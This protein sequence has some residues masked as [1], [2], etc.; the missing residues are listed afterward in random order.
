MR[1]FN[2]ILTS[3][4]ATGILV[5]SSLS[6]SVASTNRPETPNWFSIDVNIASKVK[7][8]LVVS[9]YGLDANSTPNVV[10]PNLAGDYRG[11]MKVNGFTWQV[12]PSNY[13]RAFDM[14]SF[15]LTK[16]QSQSIRSIYVLE[17]GAN[18]WAHWVHAEL[19]GVGQGRS[20]A[21]ALGF[22]NN[23]VITFN[24]YL[25][26]DTYSVYPVTGITVPN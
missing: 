18:G 2:L 26:F 25:G 13:S 15:K 7:F 8:P 19:V 20:L 5:L 6:V 1:R 17:K 10:Y 21:T 16:N 23:Q 9:N 22:A 12:L 4:I 24:D 14:K 3:F 11:S